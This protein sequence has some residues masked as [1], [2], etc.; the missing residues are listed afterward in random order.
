MKL[1]LHSARQFAN[2][3]KALLPPGAAWNWPEGGFG[4]DLLLDMAQ[5]LTRIEADTQ[6]VLDDAIARHMP[7]FGSWTLAD[8]RDVANN[9]IAG[10]SE[11]M[12]RRPFTIGSTVGQRLWSAAAAD[13][14]FIVPLVQV[15]DLVGPIRVG[16]HIGDRC[17]GT[18]SRYVLRVRYYSSVVDPQVVWDALM[19]FK[20][21][22]VYLWFEDITGSGGGLTN[23]QN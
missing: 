1:I 23:A 14:G 22:H 2:S 15:D 7:I 6:A 8:Y 9:A 18:R 16:S 10:V 5:E 4:D 11:M 17:W 12:P 3:F 19:N 20:Q 13:E 21:A